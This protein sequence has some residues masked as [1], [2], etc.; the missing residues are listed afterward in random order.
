MKIVLIILTLTPWCGLVWI[1]VLLINSKAQT[2]QLHIQL[3]ALM[4]EVQEKEANQ[5]IYIERFMKSNETL[6]NLLLE[7]TDQIDSYSYQNAHWL[8]APEARIL[9]LANLAKHI[10]K[11]GELKRMVVVLIE[12]EARNMDSVIASLNNLL[13]MDKKISVIPPIWIR[14]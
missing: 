12:K 14:I 5:K 3:E 11:P 10:Q 1:F 13:N 2:S 4:K 9:G 7:R 8:R 6:E